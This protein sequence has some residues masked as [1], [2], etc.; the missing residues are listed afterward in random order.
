MPCAMTD[1]PPEISVIIVA[2]NEEAFIRECIFSVS[3]QFSE[4]DEWELLLVDGMS[5]DNT[6]ESALDAIREAGI[7]NYHILENPGK[8][9]A[10]GWNIGIKAAEGHYMIRPDAHAILYP[11]YIK[12]GLKTI[13]GMPGVG[14]VGGQLETL[15]KNYWGDIIKEALSSRI[16]VGNSSF[17]TNAV[18]GYKDTAVYGIYRREVFEKAGYFNEELTRH[19]DNE[20][21]NRVLSK[22]FKIYMN[23]E[24]KA[25]YYCRD[26]IP[27]LFQQMYRIGYYLPD[28][29][30]KRSLGGMRLRHL[31]PGAFFLAIILGILLGCFLKI[32]LWISLTAL[33]LYLGLVSLNAVAMAIGKRRISLLWMIFIIPG[34]H[35]A[36]FLGTLAGFIKKLKA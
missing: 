11:D 24:M 9:L 13:R 15:S 7:K 16:G 1:K 19:Q 26:S 12:Q 8:T 5:E 22:G 14:V 33:A 34:M 25:G 31:A 17:R 20:F 10:T 23:R 21:H 36:Y 28:L 29:A 4:N 6:R 30:G 18:S 35:F 2:R 27:A 32:F 3:R